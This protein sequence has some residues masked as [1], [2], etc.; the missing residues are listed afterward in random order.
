M[1]LGPVNQ[2]EWNQAE[3]RAVVYYEKET[4]ACIR[5]TGNEEVDKLNRPKKGRL[6]PQAQAPRMAVPPIYRRE[7]RSSGS[8][9]KAHGDRCRT[10]SPMI[11]VEGL[12]VYRQLDFRRLETVWNVLRFV[13]LYP[14]LVSPQKDC[15]APVQPGLTAVSVCDAGADQRID[16]CQPPVTLVIIAAFWELRCG[17][18]A[19]GAEGIREGGGRDVPLGWVE[20]NCPTRT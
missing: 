2:T 3:N 18:V 10:Y 13:T 20:T 15:Q 1:C 12:Q 6:Y 9:D 16:P 14:R 7:I 4:A 5:H 8:G 19:R 17:S 11:A